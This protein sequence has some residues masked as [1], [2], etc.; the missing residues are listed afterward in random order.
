[1]I[2]AFMSV[3]LAALAAAIARIAYSLVRD[4]LG[5]FK[6]RMQAETQKEIVLAAIGERPDANSA[7]SLAPPPDP[8][9]GLITALLYKQ[10]VLFAGLQLCQDST[11]DGDSQ[12]LSVTTPQRID[13]A[14]N[15]IVTVLKQVH[16]RAPNAKILLM[17]YPQLLEN[18]GQCVPGI[19]TAEA[20]WL[21]DMG[22]LLNQRLSSAVATAGGQGV[23]VWFSD[24]TDEFAGRGVCGNPESI[25]GLVFDK[26][27]GDEPGL[28]P[29]QSQQSFHPT[30]D[31]TTLY[32]ASMNQTLGGMNL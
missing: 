23:P 15:S 32:A 18:S 20:P 12:P 16:Q 8:P 13:Q 30:N 14:G 24:P 6:Q 26:T 25:H 5:D 9:A 22:R 31:G 10:C 1:M 27:P 19:G 21:T 11:L 17:G 7:M 3:T 2:E 4:R 28:I 29:P